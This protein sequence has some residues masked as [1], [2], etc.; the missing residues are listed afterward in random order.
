LLRKRGLF[1]G[2]YRDGTL[3]D[4]LGLDPVPSRF[5]SPAQQQRSA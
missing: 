2:E 4:R 5:D 3:R 1:R